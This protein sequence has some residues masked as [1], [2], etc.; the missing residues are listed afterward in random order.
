MS[1]VDNDAATAAPPAGD[2][3][4]PTGP[5]PVIAAERVTG[6]VPVVGPTP[7]TAPSGPFDDD[8]FVLS[9]PAPGGGGGGGDDG[10]QRSRRGRRAE[11]R[12]TEKQRRSD[13]KHSVR[14][15]IFTRSVLVWMLVFALT[16]L[17][18]GASGAFWW[19]HFNGQVSELRRNTQDFEARSQA[20][21]AALE[22]QRADALA[23][24]DTALKPLQGFLSET[25][26]LTLAQLFSPAVYTVATLDEE[27]HP[28]VGTAFAVVSDSKQS[29]MVTSYT[30]IKA[31]TVNPGPAV[32]IRKGTDEIAAEV[33]NW[34]PEHDLA[35]LRVD[36]GDIQVL[37]WAS[38]QVAAK[39][40]GARVFPVSGL[41]GAG[42]SLTTGV[43]VDESAVGFQ[44][45]APLGPAFQGGPI[46]TADGKVLG[47]ASLTYRPLS[48]DPGDIRF[49][50]PI[51]T[52]CAKLLSCGGGSRSPGTKGG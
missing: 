50:P 48:F 20:A 25:Q 19:A 46:V 51:T 43:V 27:G 4:P 13:A 9:D 49:A 37:D 21:S 30:T 31:A 2:G 26:V 41:G 7:P 29:L 38:D 8:L 12:R 36:R 32:T 24:I 3:S 42:A 45:T 11:W 34:D 52:V 10:D 6:P 16:G 35:L 28:A 47:I 44:H 5:V 22:T 15:P 14:F 23:Q 40:V 39:A 1:H 33:W 17:A 18:F